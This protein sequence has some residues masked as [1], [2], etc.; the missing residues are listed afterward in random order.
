MRT[1]QAVC[2][3]LAILLTAACTPEEDA[4]RPVGPNVAGPAAADVSNSRTETRKFRDW[5]VIC[6][7]GDACFAF[8]GAPDGQAGWLRVA[9]PPG[10]EGRPA[11]SAGLWA[12]ENAPDAPLSLT[13]DGRRFVMARGAGDEGMVVT[14]LVEGDTRDLITALGPARAVSLSFRDQTVELSPRGAAA[15][16]LWIDERQGRV[17]TTTALVRRGVRA[18]ATV[19]AGDVLPAVPVAHGQA[20]PL[21][22]TR[23]PAAVELLSAIPECRADM[24]QRQG[25]QIND[26]GWRLPDGRTLW[27]IPCFLGAYNLGQ[28]WTVT[29]A[30]GG[31]SRLLS[32][33]G[34]REASTEVIN[35]E[36]DPATMTLTA[37]AKGRGLGDC[38]VLSTWVWTGNDFALRAESEMRECWGAP[39]ESWPTTWRTRPN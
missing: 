39:P 14:G 1:G 10:P 4:A 5:L 11:V 36:F 34:S 35:G 33:P 30:A 38:G 32:L 2:A 23:A 17:Q 25:V 21:P 26:E 37:F 20:T 28:A 8:A 22:E 31:Q 29:D 12:D 6:D 15:A 16:L 9:V 3:T 27:M 19:P 24:A 7:N 13:I 18:A